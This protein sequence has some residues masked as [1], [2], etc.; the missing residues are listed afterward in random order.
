M[1]IHGKTGKLEYRDDNNE[2]L[3]LLLVSVHNTKLTIK[4]N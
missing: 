3:H 2:D 4:G 1:K